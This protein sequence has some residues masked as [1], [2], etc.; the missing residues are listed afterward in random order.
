MNGCWVSE[1][2]ERIFTGTGKIYQ[3]PEY[4]PGLEMSMTPPSV[5][6]ELDISSGR[7]VKHIVHREASQRIYMATDEGWYGNAPVIHVLDD[8]SLV[9]QK[10]LELTSH[11]PYGFPQGNTWWSGIL[12]IFPSA[13]GHEIWVIR[14][15][16]A[17][18][19]G[20]PDTWS[21]ERLP[22]QD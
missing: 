20:N 6:G 18:E 1:D 11:P 17:M 15:Y 12:N 3:V 13:A 5:T 7:R 8:Q 2:G 9:E 22:W 14:E 10:S 19:Y 16:P 4:V 21:V